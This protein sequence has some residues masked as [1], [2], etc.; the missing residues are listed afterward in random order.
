MLKVLCKCAADAKSR[1]SCPTLCDPVDCSPPGSSVHGIFQARVPEWVAIAFSAFYM[2]ARLYS[3][4][5]KLRFSST[6]TDVPAR[7]RKGRG[8]RDQIHWVWGTRANI[9][10]IMEKATEFRK[11]SSCTSLTTLKPLTV[12]ITI[13]CGKFLKKWEYQ[14]TLLVS[15]E[16]CMQVKKQQLE[17]DREQQIGS[18][19]GKEYVEAAYCCPVYLTF[20]HSTSCEML[21]WMNHRLELRLPWEISTISNMQMTPL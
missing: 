7:F 4:S 10:W 17:L 3:K 18:K 21:D 13:N 2:L 9:H 12:W 1:Q 19:L 6:W 5:F 15:W 8:T 14:N 11:T 16:T 20:M